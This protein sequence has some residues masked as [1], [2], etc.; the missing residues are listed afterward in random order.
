MYSQWLL[1]KEDLQDNTVKTLFNLFKNLDYTVIKE[2]LKTDFTVKLENVD[3]TFTESEKLSGAVCYY[4]S[5]LT[6]ILH[7]GYVKN[8]E[9]LFTFSLCYMLIDHYLD[10]DTICEEEKKKTMKEVKSYI[11]NPFSYNSLCKNNMKTNLINAVNSRY[12][13]LIKDKQTEKYIIELFAAEFKSHSLNNINNNNNN[14]NSTNINNNNN[15][16][17]NNNLRVKRKDIN[18][19]EINNRTNIENNTEELRNLYKSTTER[20]GELTAV[21]IASILGLQTEKN[22]KEA[23]ELGACIQLVD[24]LLDIKD[25]ESLNIMTWARYCLHIDGNLDS[26]VNYTL[27]K[28]YGLSNTYNLFKIILS[29]GI[30]LSFHDSNIIS[31]TLKTHLNTYDIFNLNTNKNTIT[32][33][34]MNYFN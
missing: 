24:D 19:Y 3:Y 9:S 32:S 11:E 20:K 15:T 18:L 4:G 5:L 7:F 17:N 34:L 23:E 8:K 13:E 33:F 29:L 30:I 10:N 22:V 14:T 25:D 1:T 2:K 31:E 27:E 16:S 26:Y 6:S 21:V 28:I 12:L